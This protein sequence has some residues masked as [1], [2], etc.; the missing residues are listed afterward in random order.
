MRERVR[1]ETADEYGIKDLGNW[2]KFGVG[3]RV[4]NPPTRK[5]A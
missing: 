1:P 5:I 2:G 3:P 4:P